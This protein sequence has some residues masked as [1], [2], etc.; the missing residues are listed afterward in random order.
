MQSGQEQR[1]PY[2]LDDL[3][4]P[5]LDR[6]IALPQADRIAQRVCKDLDLDV[7]GPDDVALDEDVAVPERLLRLAPGGREALGELSGRVH[8]A[9][10]LAAAAVDG[11]DED[12]V[13]D[14]GGLLREEVG[15]LVDAVVARD[16]RDT[17]GCDKV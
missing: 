6:A 11:L 5:P 10:A 15:V 13:A 17:G 7:P 3:L 2:L 4:V 1:R 16:T 9:H 8:R 14:A 12:G